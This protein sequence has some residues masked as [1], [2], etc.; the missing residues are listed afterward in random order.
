VSPT[1]AAATR[2]VHLAK[3]TSRAPSIRYE[4][5]TDAFSL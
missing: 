3:M 4:I 5:V 1:S 2:P